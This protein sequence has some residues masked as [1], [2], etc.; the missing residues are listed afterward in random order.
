MASVRW[1][2]DDQRELFLERL[3]FFVVVR[4]LRRWH[5]SSMADN[6]ASMARISS[7]S[8]CHSGSVTARTIRSVTF[9]GMLAPI[10]DCADERG[11]QH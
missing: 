6:N 3:R 10:R 4:W 11:S 5:F 9:S 1:S 7:L 2:P 8:R